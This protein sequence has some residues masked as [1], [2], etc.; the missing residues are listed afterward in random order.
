MGFIDKIFSKFKKQENVQLDDKIEIEPL[1]IPPSEETTIPQQK[2][3][4][5]IFNVDDLYLYY[6][7]ELTAPAKNKVP[8]IGSGERRRVA[9]LWNNY[10]DAIQDEAIQANMEPAIAL[11]IF[12]VESG[13]AYDK[14]TGLIIVRFEKHVFKRYAGKE[15]FTPHT[16]QTAEWESIKQAYLLDK[17]AA[18]QSFSIGLAQCMLFNFNAIG[19]KNPYD[20]LQEL[21]RSCRAQ[22]ASFFSFCKKFGLDEKA[23]KEDFIGFAKRYNGVGREILYS[24]KI[25]LYLT[26]ARE[27]LNA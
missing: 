25:K 14:D 5:S 6:P 15:V 22:V 18:M 2:N 23:K 7:E 24:E 26:H 10:G 27:L 21:Q 13:R 11:A 9:S 1:I 4:Q 8:E 3:K 20:M 17:Q 19:Y 16:N 12:S